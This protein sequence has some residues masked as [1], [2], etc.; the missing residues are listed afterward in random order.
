MLKYDNLLF[1]SMPDLAKHIYTVDHGVEETNSQRCIDYVEQK[2]TKDFMPL[3]DE[4]APFP[5]PNPNLEKK[6]NMD[7]LR[8]FHKSIYEATK[9]GLPSPKQAWQDKNLVKKVALNRL[10]WVGSCA[11]KHIVQ[12][13]SVTRLAPKIAMFKYS[14]AER[15]TNKYLADC[16]DI[17]DPFSGFSARLLAAGNLNK[18]YT[19]KD[20]HPGHVAESND[21]IKYKQFKNCK[22]LVENLLTKQDIETHEALF[23][24]PPY[25]GKEHWNEHND[26]VEKSCDEWIDLCL[27]H[28]DCK[29]YVFVVDETTTYKPYIVETLQP[30]GGMF[31]KQS[32]YIIVMEK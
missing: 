9:K 27:A 11:P 18:T 7:I 21:I 14:L 13:F 2:Y 30:K 25:G 6:G 17:V 24:C 29:K 8:H 32:E 12:G 19:G 3:F 28:Y 15:L 26:E 10:K 22:V 20:I 23:T 1:T 31:K 5:Y 4:Q 16:D